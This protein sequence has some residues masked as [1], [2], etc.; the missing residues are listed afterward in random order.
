MFPERFLVILNRVRCLLEEHEVRYGSLIGEWMATYIDRPSLIKQ[1]VRNHFSGMGGLNDIVI[2][3]NNGH[4]VEH[5]RETNLELRAL[6]YVLWEEVEDPVQDRIPVSAMHLV[7]VFPKSHEEAEVHFACNDL[8]TIYDFLVWLTFRDDDWPW[9]QNWCLSFTYHENPGVR[10]LAVS[11]LADLA[12]LHKTLDPGG[13]L[14]RLGELLNDPDVQKRAEH[15]LR[16]INS[17]LMRAH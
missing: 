15:A 9:V 14:S 13:V 4:R 3:K 12:R 5:E 2:C 17:T 1:K 16:E 6:L 8:E 11:C 7:K 10:S